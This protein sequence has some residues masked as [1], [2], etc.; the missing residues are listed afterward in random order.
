MGFIGAGIVGSAL[1]NALFPRGYPVVA[2]FSRSRASAERL[3]AGIAGCCVCDTPQQVAEIAESVFITTPDDA[4]S[5]VGAEVDWKPGQSVIHCSGGGSTDLLQPAKE[6]G[7]MVGCFHPLQSFASVAQ[8]EKNLP[9]S[10][11]ALEA[12]D[13]LLSVLKGM[14]TSLGGNWVVL[15][16]GDRVLYHTAAVFACN[17]MV[18]LIKLAVDLWQS[19]GVSQAQATAALLPLLKGTL[20]NIGEIGLPQC[21]TGP[22]AR[23]DLGTI[24]KHLTTLAD[25][26]PSL[27][28]V[29]RE[30]GKQTIP[31]ALAK[32]G[33]DWA[34]AEQL[35]ALLARDGGET[36][37]MMLRSKIHR[38]RVT[39][40]RLDYEGSITIDKRLMDAAD[41][42]ANER[43]EVLN[44][45]NGARFVTYV[46]EGEEGSGAIAINGAAA[47]LAAKGDEV[48]ILAY[49]LV[50]E[51][52]AGTVSP[53]IVYLDPTNNTIIRTT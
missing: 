30:L 7:A 1:A 37:R 6:M 24:T 32:G 48:I 31:I 2:V 5:R 16:G 28:N 21:L 14:T 8:A 19:F 33:I 12:N 53:K 27:L 9:G 43:V 4:I 39:E 46:I 15:R 38:A 26:A 20:A 18:T 50:A 49:H 41:L 13:P 25:V 51:N 29:Y 23:G 22:I 52:E 35:Q 44:L 42:L 17:Y 34:R 11:F 36:M 10:T 40:V 45:S 47:R 3:A